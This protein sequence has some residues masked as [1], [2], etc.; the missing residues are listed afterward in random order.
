MTERSELVRM[1]EALLFAAAEP[2]DEESLA[3]RLPEETDVSELMADL[4]LTYQ[5]RGVNILKM[6]GRWA[7]RTAPDLAHLLERE[8]F[9]P[10]RL[11]KAA[12][13]TLAI[14]AYHQPATRAEIE[15]IRGVGISRGT[16]DVLMEAGWVRLRGRRRSP[17]RPLTYGTTDRF[18]D[19]FNLESLTDLPG[20]E[21]LKGAGLLRPFPAS[22]TPDE[23]EP[24]EGDGP[25]GTPGAATSGRKEADELATSPPDLTLLA[26]SG[27]D[28]RSAR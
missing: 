20:L 21:E 13:E 16:L 27:S 17:G 14:I 8:R 23:G 19:H 12:T 28:P 7:L 10:R 15:D 26:G 4:V 11:S 25:E 1:I 2:L 9:V 6:G 22:G 3:A 24:D 18:L 5:G